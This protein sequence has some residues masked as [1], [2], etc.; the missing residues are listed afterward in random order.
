MEATDNIALTPETK[1][2]YDF[3]SATT[4][5]ERILIKRKARADGYEALARELERAGFVPTIGH[6]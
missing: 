4:I 2:R 3:F 5:R 6:F 1:L